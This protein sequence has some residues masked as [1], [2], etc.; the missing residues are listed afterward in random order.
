[1]KRSIKGIGPGETINIPFACWRGQTNNTGELDC[2][3]GQIKLA[4]SPPYLDVNLL[5]LVKN[6]ENT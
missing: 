2:F 3:R 1:M 5:I 4:F 6:R